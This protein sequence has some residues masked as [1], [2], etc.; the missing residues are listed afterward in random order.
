ML[1]QTIR[2]TLCLATLAAMCPCAF[3]QT[4][5]ADASA[6]NAPAPSQAP[7][8]DQSTVPLPAY[9]SLAAQIGELLADPA[10]A[11][12]HWGIL[13]TN[14]DGATIYA[15]NEAQLF[16]PASNAKLFTTAAAMALLGPD[17][18]FTTRIEYGYRGDKP[19]TVHG[20]ITLIGAGDANLSDR[21]LPYRSPANAKT[22]PTAPTA[23]ELVQAN[24]EA[25]IGG[26]SAF[27]PNEPLR[28]L[29]DFADQ[30]AKAG[31][32]HITGNIV[33]DDTVFPWEPYPEDW[34]IDDAVWG[35]G[36]P[37]SGLTV[38]DNQVPVTVTPGKKPGSVPAVKWPDGI[39]A[40]YQ[41]ETSDLFTGPQQSTSHLEF[42]R[43]IGSKVLHIIGIIAAG[44]EPDTEQIAIA[45][46]AEFAAVALKQMLEE[47]GI[48]VDGVARAKHRI[49]V[50]SPGFLVESR[51]PLPNL[52]T[53]INANL[54]KI[55]TGMASCQDACPVML[56][57]V[58]PPVEEDIVLTNKVSQNL[59]AELLLHHL[60]KIYGEQYAG[61][62][63]GVDGST[64]EGARVVRQFLIHAGLQPDDFVFYDGS[65]LS[66][67]DLV[68]PRA[69]AR[70]LQFATTQP[71]FPAWKAS[72]PVGGE[73]GTLGSRFDKPPLKDH[74]FAKT[75]TL[76][77]A[78]A[79]SGYLDAASGRTVIFS[80]FVG[81]HLPNT[82]DDRIVMDKI[83]A[84][85]AAAE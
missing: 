60:G 2:A 79:L 14:L 76:G 38:N 64:A 40:Y 74:L 43:E 15:L 37:I 35:Y 24:Q 58:S 50:Q 72:L 75:G 4:A 66:T 62:D 69:T 19:K 78:R 22:P 77:E 23:Q 3:P 82:S 61:G 10:V 49:V 42:D 28:Y 71:W 46:P 9:T 36:A 31:V 39:P 33:G 20:D 65:D 48:K 26:V 81:N 30:I 12:D 85:I 68:T 52:P 45:D 29:T 27:P 67:H 44:S 13:V 83:V 51:E 73:D 7:V 63:G 21:E 80:I 70:L 59:H 47:R 5:P 25:Q 16:Q 57:R 84:A 6:A 41:L 53:A 18:R 56:Q 34:S 8:L 11:R 55:L 1:R 17:Q 54:S 32:K